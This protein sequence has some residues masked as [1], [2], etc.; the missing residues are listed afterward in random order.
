ML[1]SLPSDANIHPLSQAKMEGFNQQ[2]M[3]V[4]GYKV[5]G[6]KSLT[7]MTIKQLGKMKE[8]FVH[9]KTK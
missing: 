9:T 3:R 1:L 6:D 2:E 8:R 5:E 7:V 4:M